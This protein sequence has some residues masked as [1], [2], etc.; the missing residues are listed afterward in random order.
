MSRVADLLIAQG[1]SAARARAASG[2]IWG[3]AIEAIGQIPGHVLA[4]RRADNQF[5][6]QQQREARLDQ[7]AAQEQELTRGQIADRQRSQQADQLVGSIPRDASGN[8]D[9]EAVATLARQHDPSLVPHVTALAQKLN[10]ATGAYQLQQAQLEDHRNNQLGEVGLKILQQPN[11]VG[12]FQMAVGTLTDKGLLSKADGQQMLTASIEQ[13]GFMEKQ[14]RSWVRGSKEARAAI[15]PKVQMIKEGETP[16][17]EDRSGATPTWTPLPGF[18]P[19]PKPPTGPELDDAAQ[20][21]YAK[22]RSGQPLTPAESNALAGYEDRKRVV[23]DPAAMA[24]TERQTTAIAAQTAQ[25][26][27]AQDFA[28]AQQTRAQK[29]AEA[30][31]GRG[32]VTAVEKDYQTAAGSA[33]TLRDVVASAQA[34]N[35]V[36]ASLQ[37]LETAMAGVK[38]QGFNRINMAEIG[39][40]ASA[41]NSWDRIVGWF[42]KKAEGQPVPANI[43]KDM[44]TF[45]DILDKAAYVKYLGGHTALTKRYGLTDEVPLPA[46]GGATT[47]TAAPDYGF[48]ARQDG[49]PKGLGYLGLL[50]RPGGGVSSEISIGV[51]L[52]GKETE[53]PALVP[54]LTKD[55]VRSLLTMDLGRD[56]MPPAIVQ[57]AVDFARTRMAKGLSP[58]AA[59]GE[60][61]TGLLP[62]FS[63]AST[64]SA[65]PTVTDPRGV[66]HTFTTQAD[67][68][69]FK[70]AAGIR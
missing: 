67:A 53:V 15:E 20:K 12:S 69:A 13:P 18:T 3:N 32:K 17:I 19:T 26:K 60:Q 1:D 28:E 5:A 22:K 40:P 49:T 34:G 64:P 30:E 54:T 45:A 10:T 51:N 47:P 50:K 16:L 37:S 39:I 55:E 29:F 38:A 6:L 44:L 25:Q 11:D 62:E 14:A 61:Q 27:R 33:Q 48:G 21:L 63:R 65:R 68:D 8:I 9:V 58:F 35:K 43:Q 52:N 24:A 41:G 56:K 36:S 4:Q 46:P 42:G 59:A 57:K 70:K 31:V 23:S 2:Q 7:G 66:V